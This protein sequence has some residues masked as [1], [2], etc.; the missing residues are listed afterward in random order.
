M[1]KEIKL[2]SVSHMNVGGI[3]RHFFVV[4][5]LSQL[6]RCIEKWKIE[7]KNERLQ[8][9]GDATNVLF[10]DEEVKGFFIKNDIRDFFIKNPEIIY[11]GAGTKMSSLLNQCFKKN[12][13]GL[14]WSS[15]LP[16]TLGGA[17]RGNAG[18]FGGEIKDF[19]SAVVSLEID[20]NLNINFV[21]RKNKECQF[22]YRTS[23]F[24]KE[25]KN[26]TK[27]IIVGV[28]LKLK[29]SK[30]KKE[31]IDAKNR[32]QEIIKYRWDKHPMDFPSLGCTFK[33]ISLK[34]VPNQIKKEYKSKI[35]SD[36][37]PILPV[38]VLLEAAKLKGICAGG[39]CFSK[40]HPN[41]II[42]FKKASCQDIKKL[43]SMAK[44]RIF[45]KFGIILEE[46]IEI[47]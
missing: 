28:F 8:I 22:G 31:I 11:V 26:F 4:K 13:I 35:K 2:R 36:P 33:N 42:N 25:N 29:K 27:H 6:V 24:K 12:L 44:K 18:A 30:N 21:F 34:N 37:F 5:T 38:A 14:E 47:L 32:A 41:F 45:K 46:E 20:K 3:A 10:P 43:I 19:V 16:G 9:L 17:I 23:I 15:G 7:N 1:K 40:K 39:A